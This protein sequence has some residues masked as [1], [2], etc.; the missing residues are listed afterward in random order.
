MSV[1]QLMH[2]T[3]AVRHSAKPVDV[4]GIIETIVISAIVG[5]FMLV[6][7]NC[8]RG[9]MVRPAAPEMMTITVQPGDT[10]WGLAK[11]YGNQDTYILARVDSLARANKLS[12]GG[13]LIAGQAL[14][15]PATTQSPGGTR[16]R[17]V[18][19]R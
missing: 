19:S 14:L 3:I 2:P 4:R 8:A 10:L 6:A 15:V 18:A 16:C 5:M 17:V 7:G 11:R 1:R 12:R 9:L 13:E